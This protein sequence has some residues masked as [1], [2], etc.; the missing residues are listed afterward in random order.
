M[1]SILPISMLILH[2]NFTYMYVAGV[3]R[4]IPIKKKTKTKN[5]DLSRASLYIQLWRMLPLISWSL[6]YLRIV[7]C[8]F[9]FILA[10]KMDANL[11]D[12]KRKEHVAYEYLCHLEEAKK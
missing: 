11:M 3:M 1:G 6:L 7:L 9:F 10:G 5:A 8:F 12:E 4:S 2:Q